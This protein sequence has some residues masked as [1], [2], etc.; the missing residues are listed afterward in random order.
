MR[1]L[2]TGY[3]KFCTFDTTLAKVLVEVQLQNPLFS[4][5]VQRT[6][7]S[8]FILQVYF[9]ALNKVARFGTAEMESVLNNH[10]MHPLRFNNLAE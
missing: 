5:F 8:F 6:T 9:T 3:I 7:M 10:K 1:R 4:M 2:V